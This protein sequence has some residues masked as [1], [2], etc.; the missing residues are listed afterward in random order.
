MGF[1]TVFIPIVFITYLI[2]DLIKIIVKVENSKSWI[3]VKA[4]LLD[5]RIIK[6]KGKLNYI[7][8]NSLVF[9]Y[10]QYEYKGIK[11]GLSNVTLYGKSG[12]KDRVTI[13]NIEGNK[14]VDVYINPTKPHIGCLLPPEEHSVFFRIVKIV[15]FVIIS[16]LLNMLYFKA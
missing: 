16:F 6:H 9:F 8:K 5:A 15:V 12:A 2:Y 3:K 4:R 11:I 7:G 14:E 1:L 10:C 13:R